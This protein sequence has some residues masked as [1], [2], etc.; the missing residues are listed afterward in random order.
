MDIWPLDKSAIRAEIRQRN[1]LRQ[2][3]LLPLLDEQHE[4]EHA[5]RLVS[6][7]RWYAF[8][9]S[10]QADYDRFRD[11]VTRSVASHRG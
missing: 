1:A 2:S 5:C 4:L 8:K 7:K 10:K 6:S 9:K 11:E 3:A